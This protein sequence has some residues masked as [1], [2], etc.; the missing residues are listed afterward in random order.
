[1]T[2][3]AEVAQVWPRDGRIRIVGEVVPAE[4]YAG[5]SWRLR[6]SSRERR[7]V[8]PAIW[9]RAV[10]KMRAIAG[11]DSAGNPADFTIPVTSAGA[12]FEADIPLSALMCPGPLRWEHWDLHLVGSANGEN[13]SLRLGKY[14]DDMPGK[15]N[16]VTFPMQ[17]VTMPFRLSIRPYFTDSDSLS[18]RCHHSG[19]GAE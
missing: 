7:K 4:S 18:I 19:K 13:L 11:R 10:G 16:I 12:G 17:T 5:V 6:L 8:K 2:A 9:K 1:M 3:H 14:D 15:K